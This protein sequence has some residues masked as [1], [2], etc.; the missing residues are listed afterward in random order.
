MSSDDIISTSIYLY[1]AVAIYHIFYYLVDLIVCL[2]VSSA[3]NLC[4]Q[5]GPR[6]G[7]TKC[8]GLIWI[9]TVWLWWYSWKKFAKKLISFFKKSADDWSDWW[10]GFGYEQT[11]PV[12]KE[13]KRHRS[14]IMWYSKRKFEIYLTLTVQNLDIHLLSYNSTDQWKAKWSG[15]TLFSILAVNLY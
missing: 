1:F 5:F 3:G 2:L 15:S 11:I 12:G 10:S 9:Q 4:K 13:L 7:P 14:K 6:S 8:L